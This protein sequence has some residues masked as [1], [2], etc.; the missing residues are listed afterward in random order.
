M[1]WQIW[2]LPVLWDIYRRSLGG[3]QNK[4]AWEHLQPLPL[5]ELS[6]A[7]HVWQ[8]AST[9]ACREK[10]RH[11][12]NETILHHWTLLSKADIGITPAA[13]NNGLF[14]QTEYIL[15]STFTVRTRKTQ[16]FL[17]LLLSAMAD[18][19][20]KVSRVRRDWEIHSHNDTPGQIQQCVKKRRR[21]RSQHQLGDEEQDENRLGLVGTFKTISTSANTGNEYLQHKL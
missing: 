17:L 7:Q 19:F 12:R 3:L 11:Y 15:S 2:D 13:C 6:V 5:T 14:V 16:S 4:R 18:F 1:S 8:N 20:F 21:K 9:A 10:D